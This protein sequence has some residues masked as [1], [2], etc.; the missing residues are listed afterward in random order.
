MAPTDDETTSAQ[1]NGHATGQL[2]DELT[3]TKDLDQ[4]LGAAG[5]QPGRGGPPIDVRSL[6]LAG[7]AV[8][9]TDR[10]GTI[11][12]VNDAFVRMTGYSRREAIGQT[13]RLLSSGFQDEAF[14]ADLWRTVT[15]G[16]VWEGELIDRH[17]DGALRTYHATI[18]PVKD[19]AGRITHFVAVE[20]DL[21]GELERHAATGAAGMIHTDLNGSCVYA[22]RRA[23]ALFGSASTALLG[24]GLAEALEPEDAEQFREVVGRVAETGRSHRLDVRTRQAGAGLLHVELAPL[25]VPSGAIIGAVAALEDL[26][27]R[28]AV[29]RELDRRDAFIAGVLDALPDEVAVAADDGTVLAVNRAWRAARQEAPDDQILAARVG[30]DVEAL[31][32]RG[33]DGGDRSAAG[34]LAEL[35]RRRTTG[36]D[37]STTP[38]ERVAEGAGYTITPLAWDDGG[39]VLR[40]MGPAEPRHER[41]AAPSRGGQIAADG[42]PPTPA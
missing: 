13:P 32:R 11:V 40:R 30:D 21:T 27:E 33:A 19:P 23:A 7:D 18:S 3:V 1:A 26:S 8:I 22:N 36:D 35:H 37:A 2:E 25:T 16:Q 24:R 38:S 29:H 15:S 41:G 31:A 14:Y 4:E 6:D 12:D 10:E 42:D 5:G 9:V 34:L 17:R 28:V 20:R 39:Y